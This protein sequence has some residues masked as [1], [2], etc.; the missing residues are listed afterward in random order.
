MDKPAAVVV[1]V[2]RDGAVLAISRKDNL[3]AFGLPGGKIETGET[4][5]EAAARELLEETGWQVAPAELRPLYVGLEVG[6]ATIVAA[7]LAPE[8]AAVADI[9]PFRYVRQEDEGVLVWAGWPSLVEGPFGD[10]NAALRTALAQAIPEHWATTYGSGTL[11]RAIE[12]GMAW[13]ELYLSERVAFEIGYG[14][15]PAQKSRLNLGQAFSEGDDPGTTETCWWT[16]ALRWRAAQSG[17][18]ATLSVHHAR[19]ADGDGGA[20]EGIAIVYAPVTRPAWLPVDRCLIAFTTTPDGR[21][22]NPC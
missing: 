5:E 12:E 15:T 17:R 7:F 4:A 8:T 3:S 18:P 9:K 6:T 10:Y 16:R 21:T 1:V 2:L 22:E 11:R 13:R 20:R 14:F 19:L